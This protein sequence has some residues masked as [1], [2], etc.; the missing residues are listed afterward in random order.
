VL[1][2]KG[3]AL[4]LASTVLVAGC[5][6]GRGVA[7]QPTTTRVIAGAYGMGQVRSAAIRALEASRF[8][9]ESEDSNRLFAVRGRGR[10]TMRI[11]V[12][13][14]PT[15][16][17]VQYLE[18]HGYRAHQTPDGTVYIH[19]RYQRVVDG[20]TARFA[21][22][23]ERPGREAREHQVRLAR[24]VRPVVVS[25]QVVATTG[26][27]ATETYAA[28]SG[29]DAPSCE[30]ALADTGHPQSSEIF[31]RDVDPWCARELLYAGHSPTALM[32]CRDVDA[33]CATAHLRR[34]G[35]PTA[36]SVCR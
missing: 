15:A 36:L 21:E 5:G 10:R 17:Q 33:S 9:V 13:Y 24:A 29:Y 14:T 30:V 18:S 19:P 6:G 20:L 2:S 12:T 3:F 25:P 22:E 11:A 35:A 27:Y 1:R 26:G 31:C 34:G 32:F 8:S 23:L 7:L 4:A 16:L 28:P